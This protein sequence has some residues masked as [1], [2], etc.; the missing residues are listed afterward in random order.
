MKLKTTLLGKTY[1][2]D[3]SHVGLLEAVLSQLPSSVREGAGKCPA[4]SG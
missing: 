1:I 3:I 2:L 4:R